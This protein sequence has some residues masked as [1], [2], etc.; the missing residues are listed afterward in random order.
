MM[1]LFDDADLSQG[2]VAFAKL[3]LAIEASEFKPGDRLREVDVAARLQLS[4][5]PVRE[6]LRRLEAE[7]IIEHR[8]RVGAVIR[9]LSQLTH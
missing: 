7:N 6:A 8:P 3:M 9:T 2:G 4:R 1:T 5:T